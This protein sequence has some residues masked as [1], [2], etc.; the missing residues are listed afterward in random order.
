MSRL[1]DSNTSSIE[2]GAAHAPEGNPAALEGAPTNGKASGEAGA[3]HDSAPSESSTLERAEKM[4][5][6]VAVRVAMWTSSLGRGL[7]RL[8][9]HAREAM[10]DIWA[11]AQ[12]IRHER[13]QNAD[14]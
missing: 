9:A 13:Q 14:K 10:E 11:E 12:N 6:G 1:N 7:I 2:G 3:A 5:D 8:G 4:A